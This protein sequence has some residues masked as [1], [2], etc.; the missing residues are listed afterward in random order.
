MRKKVTIH[1]LSGYFDQRIVLK[2]L[3]GLNQLLVG[4][5][6]NFNSFI[7]NQYKI[8]LIFTLLFRTF[9]IFSDFSRFHME[10]SHLKEILGKN[11]FPIKLVD[12][13]IKT[14]LNK[15]F[16]HIP[17]ELTVE[18]KD[19]LLPYHILVIYLVL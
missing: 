18:K 7:Y 15:K 16:L 6:S 11:V 9:S 13:C 3:F 10:V 5:N 17:V 14:F 12:S 2:H 1:C 4:Y 19:C 8:G